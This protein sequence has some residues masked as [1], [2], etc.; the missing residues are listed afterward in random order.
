MDRLYTR[1]IIVQYNDF[2]VIMRNFIIEKPINTCLI[3]W[4]ER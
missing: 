1:G 4:P 3:N 2:L